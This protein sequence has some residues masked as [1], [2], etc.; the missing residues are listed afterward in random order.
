VIS[1]EF[2]LE[3]DISVT[4][5]ADILETAILKR[6]AMGNNHGVMV[7]AEGVAERFS[8][9]DL[10]KATGHN[11]DIDAYGHIQLADVELGKIIKR[12]VEQRFEDRGERFRMVEINIGYV[13]RCA[14]PIPYDQE[15]TRD[16]GYQAV[17]YLL[18]D[19]PEHK[20]DAMIC[21]NDG[22][23]IPMP[24]HEIINPETG[25]T[26]IR[27]VDTDSDSYKVA[28]SYMVRLEKRDLEDAKLVA[29]M[30][31]YLNIDPED[32]IER[33]SYLVD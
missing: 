12:E 24:F 13:L 9:A 6:R 29:R 11:I 16:L 30:A 19:K 21:V 8:E 20:A 5:V 23:L 32:F 2:G 7:I 4:Q 15:Y 17:Q 22:R 18:S 3:G 28:R 10:I 1:E 25:K 33:F 26:A 14:D 27:F 31:E